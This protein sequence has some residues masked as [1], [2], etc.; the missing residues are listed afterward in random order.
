MFGVQGS[1]YLMARVGVGVWGLEY[2]VL[3]AE[4]SGFRVSCDLGLGFYI[5]A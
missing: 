3:K 1:G 2:L 5:Q 4:G